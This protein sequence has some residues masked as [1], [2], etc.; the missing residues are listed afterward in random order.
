[1]GET[2]LV[3]PA[4]QVPVTRFNHV[5]KTSRS[6]ATTS[7]SLSDLKGISKASSST[8]N[9]VVSAIV[10]TGIR[11]YLDDKG[12]SPEK[13]LYATMPVSTHTDDDKD[14]SNKF[15]LCS[16]PLATD[17]S[18]ALEQLQAIKSSTQKAKDEIKSL[19]QSVILT[20]MGLGMVTALVKKIKGVR[21][22][23]AKRMTNVMISNVP[24]FKETRYY[25][26]AKFLGIYPL[27]VIFD[28]TGINVTVSNYADS[29]DFG[30]TSDNTM[31]PDIEIIC[32]HMQDALKEMKADIYAKALDKVG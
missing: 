21:E 32:D 29:L 22:V 19:P 4:G 17:S 18:S 31:A 14:E 10:G 30:L 20:L 13:S 9:D 23:N 24:A 8:V 11:R 16:Y 6:F 26:G 3:P 5:V 25:K 15:A 12:E 7:L 27:S 2:A 1:M 28:G